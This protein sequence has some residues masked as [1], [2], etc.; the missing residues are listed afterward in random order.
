MPVKTD[1]PDPQGF[2]RGVA[3]ISSTSELDMLT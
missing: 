2:P 3:P 1:K